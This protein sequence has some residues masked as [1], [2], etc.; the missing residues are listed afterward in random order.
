MHYFFLHLEIL[1]I[2]FSPEHSQ[3]IIIKKYISEQIF[4][5]III[6]LKEAIF[7]SYLF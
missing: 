1:I 5:V 7:P 2:L 4:F 3:L 6:A